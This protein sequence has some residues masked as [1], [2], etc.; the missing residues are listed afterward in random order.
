MLGLIPITVLGR[1]ITEWR[2]ATAP[3]DETPSCRQTEEAAAGDAGACGPGLPMWDK[4]PF[5]DIWPL[6]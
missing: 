1:V 3:A 6:I 4:L 5:I 2:R